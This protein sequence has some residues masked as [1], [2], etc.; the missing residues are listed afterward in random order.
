MLL[1]LTPLSVSLHSSSAIVSADQSLWVHSPVELDKA[2]A[3]ALQELGPVKHI[4]VRSPSSLAPCNFTI[5]K[6]CL[7][8][9]SME[10]VSLGWSVQQ[11]P[12]STVPQG[13]V[14]WFSLCHVE[15]R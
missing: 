13:H 5:Q 2:L 9:M 14:Q 8:T 12:C 10:H 11:R 3:D 4:V 15:F 1:L 6:D 7:T